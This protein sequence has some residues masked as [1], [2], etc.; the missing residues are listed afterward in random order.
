MKDI[1]VVTWG[2]RELIAE[3]SSLNFVDNF[4]S[5]YQRVGHSW[6]KASRVSFLKQTP[7]M[8]T[9]CVNACARACGGQK[10][11]LCVLL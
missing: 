11:I 1:Y 6:E 2:R 8:C 4:V 7:S 10:L 5:Q 3:F 9:V